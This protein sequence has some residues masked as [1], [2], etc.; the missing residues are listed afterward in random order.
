MRVSALIGLIAA[1]GAGALGSYLAA[2]GGAD[3]VEGQSREAVAFELSVEGHEFAEV[4]SDGL[5]VILSG[6]A[7]D[8]ASR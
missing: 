3:L 8:E 6:E 7:P 5:Q 4:Q 1:F 2:L